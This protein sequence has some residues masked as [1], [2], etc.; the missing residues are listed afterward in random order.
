MTPEDY[1]KHLTGIR[2]GTLDPQKLA[3]RRLT[4]PKRP[5][6]PPAARWMASLRQALSVASRGLDPNERMP[7]FAPGFHPYRVNP[8]WLGESDDVR[9]AMAQAHTVGV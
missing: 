9:G 5:P 8:F 4:G 6:P 3:R 7:V 2:N 1:A